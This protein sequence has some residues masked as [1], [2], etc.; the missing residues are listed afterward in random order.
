MSRSMLTASFQAGLVYP[1]MLRNIFEQRSF[2]HAVQFMA[3]VCF[4]SSLLALVLSKPNPR[5]PYRKIT[6]WTASTTWADMSAFSS[7]PWVLFSCAIAMMFFGFYG[8]FF[9]LQGWASQEGIGFDG[10]R[11]P[12][13][14]ENPSA[15]QYNGLKLKTYWLLAIM[16]GSSSIGRL[17][18]SYL[19]DKFGA[20]NV[21]ASVSI[22]SSA[23]CLFMWVHLTNLHGGLAFAIVF[24][25]FSGSVIGLPPASM[26]AVLGKDQ[27]KLGQ[28]L[29]Q[30]FCLAAPFALTGPV[31][32]GYLVSRYQAHYLTIQIFSGLC[33]LS[34]AVF[35]LGARWTADR[36]K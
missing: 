26:A 23:L 22:V 21:H 4:L 6:E 11:H 2:R 29:G 10:E 36:K 35:M 13:C 8:I 32:E 17:S 5:F 7:P 12:M 14:L 18:S 24:G 3:L 30:T 31:I 28:W 33:L 25:A 19:C 34:S 16:N 20:L 15:C 9:N 1:I 27:K